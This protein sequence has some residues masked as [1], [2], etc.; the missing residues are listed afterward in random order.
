MWTAGYEYSLR[1]MEVAAQD[2]AEWRQVV[3]GLHVPLGAIR[4][5]SKSSQ[6]WG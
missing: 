2:R 4:P 6:S 5:E 1:K 3:C